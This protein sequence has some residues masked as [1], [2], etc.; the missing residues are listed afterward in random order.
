MA[1]MPLAL[2]TATYALHVPE[3]DG[4]ANAA[5]VSKRT[6]PV[7]SKALARRSAISV[8]KGVGGSQTHV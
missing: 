2:E 5:T 1:Y 8:A 6:Q 3:E 7:L 4:P